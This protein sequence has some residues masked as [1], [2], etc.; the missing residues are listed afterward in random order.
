MD[1]AVLGA[2]LAGGTSDR[3]GRSKGSLRIDGVTF[4]ERAVVT[5]ER[6]CG[7]VVVCGGQDPVPG[8]PIL[9]DVIVGS[10]PLGGMASALDHADGRPVFI[11]AVDFPLVTVE[12][13]RRVIGRGPMQGQARIGRV[14][15]RIQP[16][17]GVYAGDLAPVV[18]QR[19]ES[20]DRS[21]MAFLRRV[22]HLT[23]VDVTD[24][25]LRNVNTP[26]DY[27]ALVAG[28]DAEGDGGLS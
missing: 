24:G 15:G 13:V 3:M 4:L 22:P 16:V 28:H 7:E 6:V 8:I 26:D 17:C 19:L 27:T 14:D 18:R 5:L 12:T 10:G 20:G 11:L 2:V 25:S 9:P 23:L 21:M 1:D